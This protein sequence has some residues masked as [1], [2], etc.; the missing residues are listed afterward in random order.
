MVDF[1]DSHIMVIILNF[2]A[3]E[4]NYDYVSLVVFYFYLYHT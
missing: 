1:L 3:N 2:I 4:A